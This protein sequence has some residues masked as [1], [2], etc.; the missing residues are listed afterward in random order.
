MLSIAHRRWAYAILALLFAS[1]ALH[2]LLHQFFVG[3]GEFG[4]APNPA[5]PWLLK[6]HGALAMAT[7]VL[8]GSV[9][10]PHVRR[11]WQLRH[12]LL[13]GL[14]VLGLLLVMIVSGYA[15]Y[16]FAG[17]LTRPTA[18]W[19]HV[20]AGFVALPVFILHVVR[21]RDRRDMP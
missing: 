16:Y 8:I 2:F 9:L 17:E 7:L 11:F 1:G 12:N 18:R 4:P 3:E 10:A 13:L 21:G 6:L 5:E 19:L 14:G 20:G 15:L